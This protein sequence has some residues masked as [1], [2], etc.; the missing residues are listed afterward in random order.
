MRPFPFV[1]LAAR[2]GGV[3]HVFVATS[4]NYK[5]SAGRLRRCEPPPPPT[6]L[7]PRPLFLR[8]GLRNCSFCMPRHRGCP[9]FVSQMFI[10]R[11][12]GPGRRETAV[13][14][15]LANVGMRWVRRRFAPPCRPGRVSCD[16][17]VAPTR[18]ADPRSRCTPVSRGPLLH[19]AP[20]SRWSANERK[21][22]SAGRGVQ[23]MRAV[24][25]RG[26]SACT[27]HVASSCRCR[28]RLAVL[29]THV[30]RHFGVLLGHQ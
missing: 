27:A 11:T 7:Y 9:W 24:L 20:S 28:S 17:A 8:G 13:A 22:G 1:S 26:S 29:A 6:D 5:R 12:A 4:D 16:L 19:A 23:K 10:V 15:S 30:V 3:T 2:G 21:C 18:P 14:V 25:G